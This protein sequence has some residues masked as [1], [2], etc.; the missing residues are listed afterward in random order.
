VD[1]TGHAYRLGGDEF[2]TLTLHGQAEAESTSAR[3]AAVFSEQGDGFSISAAFGCVSLVGGS[4]TPGDALKHA[5]RRMYADKHR[6]R[7]TAARQSADVLAKALRERNLDLSHHLDKVAQLA[8]V[9]GTRMGMEVADLEAT[10]RAAELHDVG[11]VAIP[12]EILLKSGPLTPSERTFVEQHTVMGERILT[13]APSLA[14]VGRLVRHSHERVDGTGYPDRLKGEE[15]PFGSRLIH[16]CDAYQAMTSDRPYKRAMTVEA[17]LA[18]LRRCKDTQFDA[19]IVD[20]FCAVIEEEQQQPH[21]VET[22]MGQA[23]AENFAEVLAVSDA[24]AG[25]SARE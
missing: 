6:G 25:G 21:P 22:P 3:L 10:V 24:G 1:G 20:E 5:D 2:C 7:A 17:A 14:D 23:V 8:R 19:A 12:D 15:I 9:V 4:V 18:E 16:V 13:A 11:K